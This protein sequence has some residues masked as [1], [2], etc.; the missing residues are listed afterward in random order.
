MF[1]CAGYRRTNPETDEPECDYRSDKQWRGRCPKCRQPYACERLGSSLPSRR[2]LARASES[3]STEFDVKHIPTGVEGIDD[4]TVGGI[5]ESQMIL[6]AGGSGTRKTS[7]MLRMLGGLARRTSRPLIFASAEM[8]E[9]DLMSFCRTMGVDH[10]NVLLMGDVVNHQDVLNVCDERKPLLLVLDSLQA[11]SRNS[12]QTDEY[13]A[14][15]LMQYCKRTKMC[16]VLINH[17]TSQLDIKGGTGAPHYV[18]T[19][20]FF[21]PFIPD[22]DGDPR[23][24][25]GRDA[26]AAC[27]LEYR[28]AEVSDEPVENLRVLKVHLKNRYGG[29]VGRRVYY[30]TTPTGDIVQMKL[31]S[32]LLTLPIK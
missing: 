29:G 19:I 6:L 12:N 13:I 20:L 25:F 30:A 7:L 5:C 8:N 2:Q 1:R 31:K 22:I 16:A 14:H 11:V 9:P 24:L 15:A 4:L 17:V 3:L 23:S 18:D 21:E 28:G 32:N 26:L 27:G 10:E